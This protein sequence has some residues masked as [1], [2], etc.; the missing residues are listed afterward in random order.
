MLLKYLKRKLSQQK[1]L[2]KSQKKVFITEQLSDLF[3]NVAFAFR[4]PK[5][6]YFELANT[7]PAGFSDLRFS[8]HKPGFFGQPILCLAT[9][10]VWTKTGR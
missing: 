1:K 8:D 7:V 5:S 4:S 2:W 9:S 6:G 3:V 10:T